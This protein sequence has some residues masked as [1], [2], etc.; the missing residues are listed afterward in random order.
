M[1]RMMLSFLIMISAM[2][3][4]HACMGVHESVFA[5]LADRPD[6]ISTRD[7]KVINA[8][9]EMWTMTIP[10]DPIPNIAERVR[11]HG[12]GPNIVVTFIWSSCVFAYFVVSHENYRTMMKAILGEDA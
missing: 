12:S 3:P 4:A 8:H 7:Q 5:R 11:V 1:K 10:Q 2:A 9:H 6:I